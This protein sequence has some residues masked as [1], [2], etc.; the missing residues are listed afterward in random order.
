MKLKH[1]D[2]MS[3][4]ERMSLLLEGQ[5][6]LMKTCKDG[7]KRRILKDIEAQRWCSCMQFLRSQWSP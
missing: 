7:W 4:M 5:E 3:M 6:S 1:E 2:I